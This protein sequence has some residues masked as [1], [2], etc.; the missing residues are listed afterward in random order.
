MKKLKNVK[1]GHKLRFVIGG[2]FF[3]TLMYVGFYSLIKMRGQ[4]NENMEAKMETHL[5]DLSSIAEFYAANQVSVLSMTAQNS[6]NAIIERVNLNQ[7]YDSSANGTRYINPEQE[8][9]L[10]R[11]I[12]GL[13]QFY[14]INIIIYLEENGKY[15][16]LTSNDFDE[17]YKHP[18]ILDAGLTDNIIRQNENIFIK[19]EYTNENWSV[20][21]YSKLQNDEV[22]A[23]LKLIPFKNGLNGLQESF[24][25]H[26]Y[27]STGFPYLIS[28]E[29]QIIIHPDLE[30]GKSIVGTNV[31]SEIIENEQTTGN[32]KISENNDNLII[33]Y[34][35]VAE[36]D[37]YI[38]ASFEESAFLREVKKAEK[39]VF[40]VIV[41]GVIV[42]LVI[43]NII[44]RNITKSLKESVDFAEEIAKGNLNAELSVNQKDE[45]G[46]LANSLKTMKE[47]LREVITTI[48]DGS[49]NLSA[50]SVQITEGSQQMAEGANEQAS[51]IEE[52]SSSMEEMT[53]TIEQNSE[54]AKQT[55]TIANEMRSGVEEVSQGSVKSVEV[56]K[57]VS[58]KIEMIAEIASQTNL[59]ALNA[60]I[61]A[62]RAGEHGKGFAVVAAEVRKLAER[63]KV[64]SE[65]IIELTKESYNFSIFTKEKLDKVLPVINK[66]VVLVQ[67][68]AASSQE[69]KSGTAQINAATQQ[70]SSV[71]QQN[72]SSAEELATSAEELNTQ[73]IHLKEVVSYF[74]IDNQ[75]QANDSGRMRK[76]IVKVGK[77]GNSKKF[78]SVN[79]IE[80]GNHGRELVSLDMGDDSFEKF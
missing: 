5:R 73:A 34:K 29:G 4:S 52:V 50:A 33:F 72:A 69:Q 44:S 18:K 30:S 56:N 46:Q 51:S 60:A 2:F 57:N 3:V 35:Y 64:A 59:L 54:N 65:E 62:A 14:N 28:S 71:T 43:N 13:S 77:N 38:I 75:K 53:G 19:N 10:T 40:A 20:V 70:M 11:I 17:F 47:K 15:K 22:N 32:I 37:S 7:F 23:L 79:F 24:L 36:M 61:E 41:F 49:D 1:I 63:S 21:G 25:Q 27:Y 45:V 58:E 16:A 78:P 48:V 76:Q 12:N 68:I 55:E 39:Q 26:S 9:N 74:T 67:E 66:T 8:T 6:K 80:N 31:F 42:F